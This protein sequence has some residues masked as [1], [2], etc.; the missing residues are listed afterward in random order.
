MD[1][2]ENK[3]VVE[4][5][6]PPEASPQEVT[7]DSIPTVSDKEENIRALREGKKEA[8]RR[9]RELEMKMKMHEELMTQMIASQKAT[10][11]QAPPPVDELE[12]IPDD[13]YIPKGQIQKLV[14]KT[15][16]KAEKIA[17]EAVQRA[18]QEQ[19]KARFMDRL[20]HK[21]SDFEDVVNP[22]TLDLL[23]KQDPELAQTILELKDPYKMGLQSY[24]FI[25][26]LGLAEKAPAARRAKE[27]DKKLEQNAKSIQTPQAYDKRPMAQTFQLTEAMKQDLWK[28]MNQFAS[29]ADGVPNI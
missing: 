1:E 28:E 13:D 17:Q 29:Y 23:E 14:R 26:S 25:K 4:E 22:E 18:L 19:E 16:E 24:K 9:A 6:A 10:A 2:V 27:V 3:E 21:F 5:I 20:K 8:E 7:T 11:S 12:T 15:E